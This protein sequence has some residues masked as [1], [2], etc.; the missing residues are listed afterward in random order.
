MAGPDAFIDYLKLP[1]LPLV[2]GAEGSFPPKTQAPQTPPTDQFIPA[3]TAGEGTAPLTLVDPAEIMASDAALA[4]HFSQ[5]IQKASDLPPA[6]QPLY[7]QVVKAHQELT[8]VSTM[9]TEMQ[10]QGADPE[11]IEQVAESYEKMTEK[12]AKLEL[13]FR[14]HLFQDKTCLEKN[15]ALAL[16]FEGLT[17]YAALLAYQDVKF[18]GQQLAILAS[19]ELREHLTAND[20]AALEKYLN[21][22]AQLQVVLATLHQFNELQAQVTQAKV[23]PTGKIMERMR[24]LEKSLTL[25][26]GGE[27]NAQVHQ[28][29][30]KGVLEFKALEALLF[31]AKSQSPVN[32][33]EEQWSNALINT[34]FEQL[35]LLLQHGDADIAFYENYLPYQT[36]QSFTRVALPE[37]RVA[38]LRRWSRVPEHLQKV[39]EF[40]TMNAVLYER[41]EKFWNSAYAENMNRVND[42]S[43][44]LVAWNYFAHGSPRIKRALAE[45]FGFKP[46]QVLEGEAYQKMGVYYGWL[47]FLF[48]G[49]EPPSF[50]GMSYVPGSPEWLEQAHLQMLQ[51]FANSYL[52]FEKFIKIYTELDAKTETTDPL[53]HYLTRLQRTEELNDLEA[54]YQDLHTRSDLAEGPL[55]FALAELKRGLASWD[56]GSLPKYFP[57]ESTA[58]LQAIDG[59]LAE[60]TSDGV[61]VDTWLSKTDSIIAQVHR[62]LM[63][64]YG[65]DLA[66]YVEG[67]YIREPRLRDEN[68]QAYFQRRW[69][70]N[71]QEG[72]VHALRRDAGRLMGE[73]PQVFEFE[74]RCEEEKAKDPLG[75]YLNNTDYY[76]AKGLGETKLGLKDWLI[77]RG[78]LAKA[79]E[80]ERVWLVSPQ[81]MVTM[82][83]G[84]HTN[85]L[86]PLDKLVV[87]LTLSLEPASPA[88]WLQLISDP[89]KFVPYVQGKKDLYQKLLQIRDEHEVTLYHEKQNEGFST[90]AKDDNPFPAGEATLEAI[91]GRLNQFH[92]YSRWAARYAEAVQEEYQLA[93]MGEMNGTWTYED[94]WQYL[95][96]GR[97]PKSE[98]F[99]PRVHQLRQRLVDM[100]EL[101]K[102]EKWDEVEA[103]FVQLEKRQYPLRQEYW[104]LV[105]YHEKKDFALT[106]VITLLASFAAPGVGGALLRGTMALGRAGIAG[107]RFIPPLF[108]AGQYGVQMLGKAYEGSRFLQGA[109]AAGRWGLT[110]PHIANPAFGFSHS[111]AFHLNDKALGFMANQTGLTANSPF[112][113]A[114][115]DGQI[116]ANFFYDVLAF[117]PMLRTFAVGERVGMSL[118][119][120]AW[121]MMARPRLGHYVDDY[122][123]AYYEN[124]SLSGLSSSLGQLGKG[125]FAYSRDMAKF[126]APKLAGFTGEY[127]GFEAWWLG[128]DVGFK[129]GLRVMDG[130][131]KDFSGWARHIA[132]QL[133]P[134]NM[135]DAGT[136]NL[137]FLLGLKGGGSMARYTAAKA[138]E[139]MAKQQVPPTLAESLQLPDDLSPMETT[140]LREAYLRANLFVSMQTR[141]PHAYGPKP[142]DSR[143]TVETKDQIVQ[144]AIAADP[145]FSQ[146]SPTFQLVALR[147]ETDVVS[148]VNETDAAVREIQNEA[149]RARLNYER[150]MATLRTSKSG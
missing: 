10:T 44:S 105:S 2:Q 139:M 40:K 75:F 113:L 41:L 94:H 18:S 12:L 130:E 26:P 65:R 112:S 66:K 123:N 28:R 134:E 85:A 145:R 30:G 24:E 88:Q 108:R 42:G 34:G 58:I 128:N 43:Q 81:A 132:W 16:Y 68:E 48:I 46:A 27:L 146:D 21:F 1:P 19:R 109:A 117:N 89:A 104:D 77:A 5:L 55:R 9:M 150:A 129:S 137:S 106:V 50:E 78:R 15:A 60:P 149:A 100:L 29:V 14:S 72:L 56:G 142:S 69:G 120:Q 90:T 51:S 118:L 144:Q 84:E 102:Q 31:F 11:A 39:Q 8:Q 93:T 52:D 47:Q 79:P 54:I 97:G 126:A 138:H 20:P 119:P 147:G 122:A 61:G 62:L 87:W 101:I 57:A 67:N 37:W 22:T 115:T 74:L 45:T 140:L 141:L 23:D 91:Q 95:L 98:P 80:L 92:Y 99:V 64:S 116:A 114:H 13:E 38:Q 83:L 127:A 135:V 96:F 148:R 110:T 17:H 25:S 6:L 33:P 103:A 49:N 125:L 73:D 133:S 53:A 59:L 7:A 86:G 76:I 82:V 124:T 136:G 3:P 143:A 71:S 36:A 63:K 32:R 111:L 131:V 107:A 121:R 4:R 35:S 70:L